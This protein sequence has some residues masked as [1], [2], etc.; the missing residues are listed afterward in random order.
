[1][2]MLAGAA[3]RS[4]PNTGIAEAITGGEADNKIYRHRGREP[5]S[6]ISIGVAGPDRGFSSI[7][8]MNNEAAVSMAAAAANT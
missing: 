8:A 5:Y 6:A 2:G 4:N 7:R 1:M 3:V